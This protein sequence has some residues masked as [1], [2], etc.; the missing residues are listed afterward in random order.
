MFRGV[1]NLNL[2]AKG[3]VAIPARYRE[4]LLESCG[5]RLVVTID[6]DG[7]LL[8]YPL[9]EWERIEAA[10]MSRPNM[11]PQVRSLQR[12][13]L[14]YASDVEMDAQSR[15]LVAPT[16]RE[17]AQLDKHV[18]LVGQGNKFELWNEATW[19][20]QR[21]QWLKSDE[22]AEGLSEALASLSL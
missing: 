8:V 14:G 12:L 5:G 15:I 7:C 22:F 16:L 3:R 21:E 1:T 13:L 19:T 2:D 9:T 18:V 6:R 17:H 11:D 4:R 20:A 10:L